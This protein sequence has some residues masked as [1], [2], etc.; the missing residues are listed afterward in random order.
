MHPRDAPLS[1]IHRALSSSAGRNRCNRVRSAGQDPALS[2]RV[3]SFGRWTRDTCKITGLIAPTLDAIKVQPTS[4]PGN[5]DKRPAI[6][7]CA[8]AARRANLE[9]GIKE[10]YEWGF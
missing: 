5:P 9:H 10:S 6:F 3:L 1:I 2:R 4:M 7:N 8:L